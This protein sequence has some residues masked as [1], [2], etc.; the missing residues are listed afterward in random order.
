MVVE[1]ALLTAKAGAADELREALRTARNVI[2]TA[3]GY[4]NGVFHQ[5]I[6]EPDSFILRIEWETLEDHLRFRET[7]LLAAWRQPFYHL[8]AGP[9]KVT[10][11]QAFV[12]P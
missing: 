6:E 5:G 8:L 9:P 7:P 10:H 12:G 4:L 2:A 1:I 3:P 11:Y